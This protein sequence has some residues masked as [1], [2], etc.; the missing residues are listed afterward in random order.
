MS[1]DESFTHESLEDMQSIARYLQAV[2][3]GL[4]RGK[5]E[6]E[7]NDTR[8]EL[9]PHGL[10]SFRVKAK[11]KGERSKLSIKLSWREQHDSN[12]DGPLRVRPE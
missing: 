4:Q 8:V 2:L 1:A 5:I 6:L 10:I 11:R 12:G 7:Q 9:K 3:D